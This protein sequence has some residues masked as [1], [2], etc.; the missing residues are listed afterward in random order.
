MIRRGASEAAGQGNP[1]KHRL[2]LC[3]TGELKLPIVAGQAAADGSDAAGQP[4][5]LAF[6]A[7]EQRPSDPG[8]RIAV[9]MRAAP[10]AEDDV[11]FACSALHEA[12]VDARPVAY[13]DL[14]AQAI[15]AAL[16]APGP[17]GFAGCIVW[18]DPV[19]KQGESRLVLNAMLRQLS[20]SGLSVSTHP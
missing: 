4:V 15:T 7:A 17:D 3:G 12:G 10:G 9:I 19:S 5:M 18:V 2:E 16:L 6:A 14:E 13:S 1:R 11:R 20:S 8:R